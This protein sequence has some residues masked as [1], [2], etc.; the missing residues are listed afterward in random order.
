MD[1]NSLDALFGLGNALAQSPDPAKYP[2]A[3]TILKEFVEKAKR[4]PQRANQV[5]Q[6]NEMIAAFSQFL[7][8]QKQGKGQRKRP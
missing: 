6:A 2:E 4:D 3:V 1:P 8:E 5:Q 7:E